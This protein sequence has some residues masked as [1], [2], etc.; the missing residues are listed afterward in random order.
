V[1]LYAFP[2]VSCFCVSL[3]RSSPLTLMVLIVSTF[4]QLNRLYLDS[5]RH[6][7]NAR[8]VSRRWLLPCGP[9]W[10]ASVKI[11]TEK[12]SSAP[13]IGMPRPYSG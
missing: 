1:S 7:P 10:S 4:P 2:R 12:A 8:Y 3:T 13:R 9:F 5:M 11:L 6:L